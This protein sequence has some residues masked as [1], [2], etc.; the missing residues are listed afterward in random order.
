MNRLLPRA[1][2]LL[3]LVPAVGCTDRAVQPIAPDEEEETLP[4]PPESARVLG[5][6]EVT[7]TGIG[8]EEMTG[9]AVT[10]DIEDL[11]SSGDMVSASLDTLP[12]GSAGGLQLE[13]VSS[14]S[15]TEGVR[16]QGG[17]RYLNATFRVRNAAGNGTAYSV[18]RNN[19]TFIAVSTNSTIAGTPFNTMLRFDGSAASQAIAQT[20]VPAGAAYLDSELGLQSPYPDVLQVFSEG[21]LAAMEVRPGII[22][23]RFPYGFVVR[24]P[25]RPN[26]RMLPANPGPNQFDGLVNFA[27]RVP[28]QPH[29]P[30]T[31][32]GLQKDPF[33]IS[34]I[35]LAV[36]DSETRLTES[37][38]EHSPEARARI[39]A[40]VTALGATTVSVLNGSPST[41]Y[42]GLRR[43]C[44]V[45]TAGTNDTP[46]RYI[47]AEAGYTRLVL[48]M[49][50][51]SLNSCDPNFVTGTPGRPATNV[52]FPVS[53]NAMDRYGNV[54]TTI[55]DTVGLTSDL[56]Y[57]T[58][59]PIHLVN[60]QRTIDITF[61]NYGNGTLG[62]VGRR[63]SGETGI[64]VYGVTR[65]WTGATST[66]WATATNWSQNAAPM[67]Q[68]S[69]IIPQAGIT[70]FPVLTGNVTIRGVTVH[71][72]ATLNLGSFNLTA[73]ANVSTGLSGGISSSVGSLFL[74]GT[75]SLV[76][77]V[78]PR[79]RV[80]GTYSLSG[81]VTAVAPLRVETGRMRNGS[82]RL[83]VASQ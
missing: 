15:F 46:L 38:E 25:D 40:R 33:T 6:V 22:T 54:K 76:E 64:N 75:A 5:L 8:T 70:N 41:G 39:Q 21:E 47:N 4:D 36:E 11:T 69:V 10:L 43:L 29:D 2:L 9:S 68:D 57:S 34:V 72:G 45:R 62:A 37:I 26:D 32:N 16:G 24:N 83:R 74:S 59:A 3:F 60:G 71:N 61:P 28:L 63:I 80:T 20:V 77:G 44:S 30:G 7:L 17:H 1:A 27:F 65:T 19:V 58:P 48:L 78:V 31:G 73:L 56:P 50:G 35:L 52:A 42:P 79:L 51:Q 18:S 82:Y 23:N 13:I 67:N 12:T 55:A 49:P 53:V 14:S 66:T 81:N